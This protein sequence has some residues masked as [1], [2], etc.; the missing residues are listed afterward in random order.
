MLDIKFI[1]EN[2][3]AVKKAIADKRVDLNLDR[4]LQLDAELREADTRLQNLRAEKN[5]I[6]ESIPK[7][8]AGEKTAAVAKSKELGE[9]ISKLESNSKASGAEFEQLMWL[10]PNIPAPDVPVGKDDSENVVVRQVG[11]PREFGFAPKAH[12]ELAEMNNWADFKRIPNV[13]G[14]R[15]VALKGA[16]SRLEIALHA[17]MMDKLTAK[18]FTMITVPSMVRETALYGT[19]HFPTG[20]EEVYYLEKDDT[21]LSGTAEVVLTSLHSSEILEEAQLPLL[22]AGY[23]PCFRREAG[24]AGKDVRG[25]FRV[26]QFMKVEQYVI[27][28]N[29]LEESKKWYGVLLSCAEE[30][31]ADLEL[32][33]QVVEC[34]TG[35]MGAG[36]YKMN[37]LE[38]WMP[39]ENRYRE[40]HSCSNLTEW[41]ARRANLRYRENGTNKVR[42]C[43]TL[44]NTGIAT[45]RILAQFI[46]NHQTEDGRVR[47]PEKIRPYMNNNEYL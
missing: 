24:S 40:T 23:S 7:L 32:P 41:Q 44:N 3:D 47:L 13:C 2:P 16:L 8:G 1:R 17:Y 4:L 26:H 5:A 9:E 28:K 22:Y 33:Y 39:S 6:S 35:D 14:S 42:H 31:L 38:T 15:S 46:E 11:K 21:Y 20:R 10:V 30:V 18:G 37:D 12:W 34:C 36:K 19:G 27:C 25:L 45:P 29:D 43:F